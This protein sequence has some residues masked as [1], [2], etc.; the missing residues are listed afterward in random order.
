[1]KDNFIY[2]V[3]NEACKQTKISFHEFEEVLLW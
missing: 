2:V 1:M 3:C